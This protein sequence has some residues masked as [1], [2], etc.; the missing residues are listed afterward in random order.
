MF[1]N[2][3]SFLIF[4][5]IVL[6][7]YFIIPR[8][9]RYV[10]LLVTSYYF[11]MCWNAKYAILLMGSTVITYLGGILLTKFEKNW[12]KK[13]IVTS[14]L[15]INIGILFVFKYFDFTMA[16][17]QKVLAMVGVSFEKPDLQLL[18]PMGISFYIF[19]AVGYLIDVYRKKQDAERNLLRYAL[20]V[21][22]FPQLVAGPIERYHSLAPQ[23]RNVDKL[24]LFDGKRIQKGAVI[25]LYGFVL[26]MILA[27]RASMMVNVVFD[28]EKYS[29][30]TGITVAIAAILFALQIYG[31][32]AG[33]TYIAIGAAKIMGFSLMDNF[34]APYFALSIKDFWDRWH[35]SLSTWFRDYLYISLGGSRKGRLIK[36]V[37]IMIIFL[38]SGLWHGAA[39]TY[40]VWG[41]LHGIMRIFGELTLGWRNKLAK[42]LHYD[43]TTFATK[44]FKGLCTFALVTLA[45]IFFRAESVHQA[46]LM[47]KNMFMCWNPWILTD[48]SL[49]SMGLDAK[50]WTVLNVATLLLICVDLCKKKKIALADSFVQQNAWFKWLVLYMGIVSVILFGVYGADY[51]ASQFIYFQF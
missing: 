5:P 1:F 29:T 9:L 20:F 23:L 2:S 34:N 22:F 14:T 27:D 17:V 18:L 47:I 6:L 4:F 37:N 41:G 21:S 36:Y 12:T 28:V 25:M 7:V 19:Q 42:V 33:Y 38:V 24:E 51:N 30:Y 11:Y 16:S 45:W 13:I 40:V 8:R 3:I 15:G 44:V 32:F 46:V 10:W 49:Y 50:E 35:I 43:N 48:G 31:D 39:W 26:K